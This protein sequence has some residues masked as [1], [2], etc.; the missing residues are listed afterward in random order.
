MHETPENRPPKRAVPEAPPVAS[1][2][3]HEVCFGAGGAQ[4]QVTKEPITSD[5]IGAALS[6]IEK[7]FSLKSDVEAAKLTYERFI[8]GPRRYHSE[9]SGTEVELLSY[10]LYRVGDEPAAVGGAYKLLNE[11]NRI[12]M[13]WLGVVPDFRKH[14]N[15][16]AKPL[17]EVV[18][19]DA[20]ALARK[21]GETGIAAVAED[22][23]ANRNTHAYYERHGFKV[24]KTFERNGELDRLYVLELRDTASKEGAEASREHSGVDVGDQLGQTA[25]LTDRNK[26]HEVS[27]HE[28]L[29]H[30]TPFHIGRMHGEL[31]APLIGDVVQVYMDLFAALGG[32]DRESIRVSAQAFADRIE[33]FDPRYMEEI[34][35]IASGSGIDLRDIL[36]INSRTEIL[37]SLLASSKEC[38]LFCFAHEGILAQTWD[39]LRRLEGKT[40]L[41]RIRHDDGHTVLTMTEPGIVGKIGINSAGLGV[42]LNILSSSERAEG[43]PVH[44]LLRSALDARSWDEAHDRLTKSNIGTNSAITLADDQGRCMTYEYK[45]DGLKVLQPRAGVLV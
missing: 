41:L 23:P 20:I 3:L 22:T 45:G 37:T 39:W 12:Y 40:V 33:K 43:V 10:D 24:E 21:R 29:L 11:P 1:T 5:N 36:A 6:V 13:G 18:L 8:A 42:G 4:F 9:F 15:P 34:R 44:V 19:D 2:E 28:L 26:E 25:V 38:T 7:C 31:L 17:S 32:G 14:Q 16:G 35:G 27:M 30:G